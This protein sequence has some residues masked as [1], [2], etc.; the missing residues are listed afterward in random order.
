MSFFERLSEF[1]SHSKKIEA[2]KEFLKIA[3]ATGWRYDVDRRRF[4]SPQFYSPEMISKVCNDFI[5]GL[6]TAG[7]KVINRQRTISLM[8]GE[9]PLHETLHA[10]ADEGLMEQG[11]TLQLHRN[12][13]TYFHL[14]KRTPRQLAT[15]ACGPGRRGMCDKDF[16][17]LRKSLELMGF[18]PDCQSDDL[19]QE[20][21]SIFAE[22]RAKVTAWRKTN[23]A[24]I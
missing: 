8:G 18:D 19:A 21:K 23:Q 15:L 13:M 24:E 1:R 20:I 10:V 7:E 4:I 12:G 11:A 5:K 9:Y 6:E 3:E 17:L 22:A 16:S 2:S 14:G